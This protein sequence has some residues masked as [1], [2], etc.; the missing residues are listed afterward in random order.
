MVVI[1]VLSYSQEMQTGSIRGKVLDDKDIP[2]PG[3]TV[4]ITGPALLGKI[5]SVTNQEGMYRAPGLPPGSDYEVR[6]ELPGFDTV[7]RKGIVVRVG[8]VVTI[9]IQMKPATLEEEVTVIAASPT[10][11]VVS[12]T[13][14]TLISTEALSSL[15]LSRTF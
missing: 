5:T 3:V 15:P 9:D 2:L 4:T 1:S 14:S 11:D 12:S 8:M 13:K 7:V 6:T 10:I